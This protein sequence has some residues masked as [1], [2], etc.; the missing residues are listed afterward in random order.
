[1]GKRLKLHKNAYRIS[2]A[3]HLESSHLVSR[4]EE[5]KTVFTGIIRKQNARM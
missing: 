5:W 1:M 3:K 4:E 2:I